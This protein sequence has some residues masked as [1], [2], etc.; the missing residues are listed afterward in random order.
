MVATW[1]GNL[2]AALVRKP[3]SS[4]AGSLMR[5]QRNPGWL[6]ILFRVP[7]VAPPVQGVEGGLNLRF[8]V[9]EHALAQKQVLNEPCA[10]LAA[11]QWRPARQHFLF[12]A[13]LMNTP[14]RGSVQAYFRQNKPELLL[15]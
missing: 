1:V 5:S 4:E 11:R 8:E 7:A 14:L 12:A 10:G 9:R 2:V 15:E 13:P 6:N 3:T